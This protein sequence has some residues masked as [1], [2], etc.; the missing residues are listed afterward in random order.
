MIHIFLG[1]AQQS[2]VVRG[3]DQICFNFLALKVHACIDYTFIYLNALKVH[4][5]SLME[6]TK[7]LATDMLEAMLNELL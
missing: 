6:T 7:A 5:C 2:K 3:E 1:I 4:A